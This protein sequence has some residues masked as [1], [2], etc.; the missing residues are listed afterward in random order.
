[1]GPA[2]AAFVLLIVVVLLVGAVV[3]MYNRLV[4]LR[5]I[6]EEAWAGIDV[7]L[8][9]R[10]DLIPNLVETVKGYASH[11]RE[12]LEAVVQ[13]R[14]RAVEA[15]GVREQAQAENMLTQALG[16]LFALAESYPELQA[17]QN[18]RELQAELTRTE[19]ILARARQDYNGAVR[20]YDTAREVFPTNLV[21]GAFN[22][23][24]REYFEVDDPEHR[25]PV[26]VQF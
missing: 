24:E 15:T 14:S 1:M 8:V 2:I 23:Q 11:E 10:H 4:R 12:T 7:Q 26:R 5:N 20:A 18:F 25:D 6:T 13:A 16:R 21:A 19:D 3:V 22:F 17:D 9:R